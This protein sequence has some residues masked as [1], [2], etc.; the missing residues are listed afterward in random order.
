MRWDES[1]ESPDVIDRRGEEPIRGGGDGEGLLFLLPWLMRTPFGWLVI[2]VGVLFYLGRGLVGGG[3]D[4]PHAHG[5][6]LPMSGA[7]VE[8]PAVHFVSFVLDDVQASWQRQFAELGKPYRHAKLVLYTDATQTGCGFGEAAT[9]PFY[10]PAD[11]RVYIDLG[12]FHALSAK[13]GARG[14]F[15]QAYVVAHEMGHHVQKLL[16]ISQRVDSMRRTSGATGASVRLE[17]QADC[18]AGIWAKSTAQR[19]LL[20]AGDIDS[21]VGAAAAVGDDRLQRMATGTVSPESWTHGSSTERVRWFRRGFDTGSIPA[22]D[23]FSASSL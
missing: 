15:A 7:P 8:T 12:F 17:L 9:G 19:D 14:Q 23:T 6:D 10:C 20:E 13:L 2:V 22:C 18:F 3:L 16:G 4:A 1:H 11:E 5:G 21:A